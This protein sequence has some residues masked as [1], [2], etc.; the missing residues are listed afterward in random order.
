MNTA[1]YT[2][3]A[4]LLHWLMAVLIIW[5]LWLGLSMTELP[6]GAERSAAYSLHKSLGLLAWLLVV[7]RLAWRRTHRP[8]A[9]LG[10]G[11]EAQLA[12]AVHHGLYL[13]MFVAP[14]AGYLASSFTPYA[15]KFFGIEL[16]K[17]GWPDEGLNGAFKLLH[18][19]F[20]WGGGG[21]IAL[22]VAGALK[23]AWQRDGTLQRMLPGRLFKN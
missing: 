22:H 2:W 7:V 20:V 3:P 11:W 16:A 17:A 15:I 9:A 1:R 6:K 10:N 12:T 5:L 18:F 13:F 21:L 8:P 23:H 14:L 4:M 19:A